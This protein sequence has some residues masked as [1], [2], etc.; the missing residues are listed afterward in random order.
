M[1]SVLLSLL[2]PALLAAQVTSSALSGTVQDAAGAVVPNAKV[3]LIGEANGFV[4]TV[5][6]T[7]EGF[8]SFPDITPSTFTLS[9]EVKGFKTYRQTGIQLTASEQ[10]SLGQIKL[11]VGQLTESVTVAA[12]AVSVDLVSGERAGTMTG[13]QLD[14]IALRGRDVFDAVSLMA[15]VVDTSDGRDSPGPTSIANIY[16]MGG[17]GDQKNMTIDGVTNLDTGSNG[18]VHSMPSMDS[19]A[20]MKVMLAAYSAENGR[21]PFAIS[22]ITRGGGRQFHGSGGYYF[23]NEDL[24]ANDYFANAAAKPR[25]VYRYNIFNYT[26]GG[27]VIIPKHPSVRNRLF[28]FW[29]QEWQRQI[30]NYGVKTV[31]VPTALERAGKCNEDLLRRSACYHDCRRRDIQL[32]TTFHS[33]GHMPEVV[34]RSEVRIERVK[35]PVR[36]AHLPAESQPVTF[37][38]HGAVAEH[39]KVP[40]A[41]LEPHATTLDYIVAAAA[42]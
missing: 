31:T 16:I 11:D 29:S 24:N 15:G 6:T 19:I 14:E 2:M 39:Y 27:P 13:Q 17:R 23:R 30:A 8:F 21:N 32:L 22:V 38:V 4:R 33:G 37:G 35:G 5:N 20:E 18:S 3:T 42:G 40:A 12:E 1:R 10:K 41:V 9:V 28:F 7:N 34:Y 36:R 25:A 26:F